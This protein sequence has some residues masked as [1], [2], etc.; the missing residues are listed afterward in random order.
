[1][2]K[3]VV[4]I[5]VVVAGLLVYNYST[6]GT[7][8]LVPSSFSM[9]DEERAVNALEERFA[10]AR[11]QYSQAGRSAGLTGMDTTGDAE[12]ALRSVQTISND[13]RELRKRLSDEP[14]KQKAQSLAASIEE[15]S[16]SLR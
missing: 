5:V 15:Y 7:L 4:L 12:G 14:A 6:T 16:T 2:K 1:M 3:L 13:L 9:S 10:N 8:S 11:K